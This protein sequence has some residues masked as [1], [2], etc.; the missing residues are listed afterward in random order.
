MKL[1][2]KEEE[3]QMFKV[4]REILINLTFFQFSFCI[5]FL[6]SFKTGIRT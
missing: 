4:S 5:S 3:K 6:F 2:K 1:K